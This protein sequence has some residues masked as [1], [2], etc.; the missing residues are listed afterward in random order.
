M[1]LKELLGDSNSNIKKAV[2]IDLL[3]YDSQ[4]KRTLN[5]EYESTSCESESGSGTGT[6]SASEVESEHEVP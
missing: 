4:R 3:T 5:P 1:K 6:S 2:A